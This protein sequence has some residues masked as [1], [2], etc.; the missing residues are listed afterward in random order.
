MA[1][2]HATTVLAVRTKE[3]VVLAA[4]GQVTQDATVV[5]SS[6]NKLRSLGAG[7]IVAGFAG[8]TADAITLFERLEAKIESHAGHLDRA[9]VEMAKDWRS[10]KYLRRLE[11]LMLVADASRILLVSGSG[12]VIEPDGDAAAIGSGGVYALAAARAFLTAG[13]T[14]GEKIV[15]QAMTIAA[16]LCVYTNHQLTV[17]SLPVS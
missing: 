1:L 3:Q 17:L 9:A 15:R 4:D 8:S 14:D 16:D 10:D 5:K 13:V 2:Y 11:A 6:A 12:D 7:R